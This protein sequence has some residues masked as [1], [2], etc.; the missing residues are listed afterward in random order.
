MIGGPAAAVIGTGFIGP[1]HVEALRRIGVTVVGIL[2]SRL[3]RSQEAARRLGI[4]RAYTDLDDL[5]SDPAVDVV[6]IAS[7][8][9]QHVEQAR[10]CLA[11]GRHV[12]CE[13]PLAL[14]ATQAAE[15]VRVAAASGK[16]AA[17]TYNIRSYPL[18]VEARERIRRGAIGDVLHVT[19]S[20]VQDWLLLATD[21]N[22]RV[23]AEQAGETRAIGDIGTHWLDLVL[24]MTGLEVE[25]V[26]ADLA[27][28]LPLRLRPRG[29][30]ETFG[31]KDGPDAAEREAVE[32]HTE[33]YGSVLLRFRTGARG[34]LTVSQMTAGRKNCLRYEIAGTKASLAW[35]SEQPDVLWIG[36]RERPN[37][38][39]MRDPALLSGAA[40]G[41]AHY[42]GG[43]AEGFPDTFKTLFEAIY[44]D[45]R[46]GRRPAGPTYPTF[47]DGEHEI[48]LCEA[49]ARSNRVEGWVR[50]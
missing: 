23:M 40:R 25:A 46:A 3:E 12:I 18:A 45:I 7:P 47:A 37:E 34:V 31:G 1:V 42:P 21:F 9:D 44:A 20:Y 22:W 43:H 49:I 5:L 28:F 4:P 6:H 36:Y 35:N 39:L 30:V 33:D 27:T 8:N 17:V 29:S 41:M 14:T 15:L 16:V 13:K 48:R 19:G 10:R 38:V 2:G 11:A 32:V 24:F 50:L 26:C